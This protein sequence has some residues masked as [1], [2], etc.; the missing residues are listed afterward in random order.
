MRLRTTVKASA[1]EL[2]PSVMCCLKD[3]M[4]SCRCLPL[5]RPDPEAEPE[6]SLTVMFLFGKSTEL[7]QCKMAYLRRWFADASNRNLPVATI[8]S[9]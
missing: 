9:R 7:H 2:C 4:S 5:A 1:D 6:R 3:D 8:R